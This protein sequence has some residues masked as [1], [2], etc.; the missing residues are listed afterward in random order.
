ML[1]PRT[2]DAWL[3]ATIFAVCSLGEPLLA[4]SAVERVIVNGVPLRLFSSIER[5]EPDLVAEALVRRWSQ[6]GAPPLTIPLSDGRIIIGRQRHAL[7]ETATVQRGRTAGST[8][9][10]YAI[11]DLRE[12]IESSSGVPF[13]VPADWQTVSIVRHGRSRAAPLT[14]LFRTRR[15]V[16]LTSR[17]LRE[18]LLRAGW[19]APS[20]ATFERGLIASV[21]GSRRLEAAIAASDSGARVVIQVDGPEQ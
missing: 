21:R 12:P 9:V 8:R 4:T 13:A 2:I 10:E 14:G 11:R 6:S 7:H 18:A 16:E 20:R 15:S 17:Q 5:G 19:S 1:R 3:L